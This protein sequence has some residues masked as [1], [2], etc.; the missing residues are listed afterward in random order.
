M[1]LSIPARIVLLLDLVVEV[2]GIGVWLSG[3][4]GWLIEPCWDAM[5]Q[6][7]FIEAS[8]RGNHTSTVA[9]RAQQSDVHGYCNG[10]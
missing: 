9:Q 6:E 2:L 8:L 1:N 3:C 7:V 4:L 5:P 10:K